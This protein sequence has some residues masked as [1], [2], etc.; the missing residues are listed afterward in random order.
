MGIDSGVCQDLQSV[1]KDISPELPRILER[2]YTHMHRQPQLSKPDRNATI[3][4][5]F[6]SDGALG[7]AFQWQLRCSLCGRYPPHRSHS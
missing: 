4:A 5:R 3:P 7:Q 1:W 2:F 6:G